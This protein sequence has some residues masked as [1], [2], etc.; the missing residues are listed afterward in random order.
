VQNI[1]DL[2]REFGVGQTP[3]TQG[4]GNDWTALNAEF[5]TDCGSKCPDTA[6]SV[7]IALGEGQLTAVEQASLFATL[8]DGGVYHTPHVIS[9][10]MRGGVPVP[11]R[12]V[13]DT[14]LQPSAAADVDFALEAD[15]IPGG[16]AYP[17]AAWPGYQVIGKTGTTQTAQDA[18]FIGSVPQQTM[19]VA[20]FTNDQDSST[21]PGSQTLDIMPD[22]PGNATGGYG[23]AWPAYIWHSYMTS[24][25][26]S[27]S[28]ELFPSPNY[29]GF[30][31]WNQ[32][33][34]TPQAPVHRKH[35]QPR[36]TTSNCINGF[37]QQCQPGNGGGG[38]F[39]TA[40]PS[41]PVPDPTTTTCVPSPGN[42]CIPGQARRSAG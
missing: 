33:G 16:T 27:L 4:T 15:N 13:T 10:I 22:L 28:A 5:G 11:S 25:F 32:V 14:V 41:I 20:M 2:A 19:A 8:A 9:Q 30:A 6:G 31:Q 17:D 24:E 29:G 7:A 34:F 1:I 12:V 40:P 38:G 36:P 35:P 39:P 18:W 21:A 26:A 37:G 42:P 23:G 3:F